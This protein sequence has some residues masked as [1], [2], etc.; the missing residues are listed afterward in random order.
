VVHNVKIV[1]GGGVYNDFNTKINVILILRGIRY[2]TE[3]AQSCGNFAT[4]LSAYVTQENTL[5]DICPVCNP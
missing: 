4:D 3:L 2:L 5:C 1:G